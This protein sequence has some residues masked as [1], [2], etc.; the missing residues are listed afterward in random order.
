MRVFEARK[1]FY[2]YFCTEAGLE[3]RPKLGD[4]GVIT[5]TEARSMAKKMLAQVA[6]GG[7]RS[8][9]WE[10]AGKETILENLWAEY[11]RRH[12]KKEEVWF[13]GSASLA[14]EYRDAFRNA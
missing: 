5:L 12:E 7:A 11:W 13:R 2:L 4:Y 1:S 3:H 14:R 9:V 8:A 10:A 6:L